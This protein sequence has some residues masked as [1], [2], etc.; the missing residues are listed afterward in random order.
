[1]TAHFGLR[2]AHS[3]KEEERDLK[4]PDEGFLFLRAVIDL[5]DDVTSP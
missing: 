1:M 2:F 5:I 4:T 3:N